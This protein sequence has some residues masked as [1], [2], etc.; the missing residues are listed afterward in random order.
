MGLEGTTGNY[1]MPLFY[2]RWSRL[3]FQRVVADFCPMHGTVTMV[4][5]VATDR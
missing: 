3:Y 2:A 1:L 4:I 5:I